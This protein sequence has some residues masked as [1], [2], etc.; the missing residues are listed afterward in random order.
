MNIN[1]KKAI[2]FSVV[3]LI[4][5]TFSAIFSY[6]K[7]ISSWF[8]WKEYSFGLDIAGGTSLTYKANLSEIPERDR[9][10]AMEGLRDV[11]ERRVNLFGVREPRVEIAR[12]G[13]E[14]RLLVELAGIKDINEAIRVI[15][16]TPFLEFI[17]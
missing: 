16:D 14:W 7:R 17:I 4:L 15:G 9:A 11:V 3:V 2:F 5:A 1:R 8:P 12:Q 10:E 13:G 6:P